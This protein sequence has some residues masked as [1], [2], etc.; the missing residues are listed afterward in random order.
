MRA[1]MA[2]LTLAM[3][4]A[5]P[6]GAEAETPQ[7]PAALTSYLTKG[8]VAPGDYRWLRGRFPG[9]TADEVQVFIATLRFDEACATQSRTAIRTRLAAMGQAFDPGEGLYARP[10]ECRQFMQIWVAGDVSWE[11]FSAALERVRPYALGILRATELA[12][13]QVLDHGG[14]AEQ[15]RTRP[16]GEQTLRYAWI[17]SQRHEG[18]T[19]G[20]SP[21]ERVIYE[22]ILLRALEERDQTNTRWLAD[23]VAAHGWPSRLSVGDAASGSAWLLVQ[24]ADADPAFQLAALRLMTPLAAK[25]AV[26]PRNFAM[27]TDRIQLKLSGKQRYGTQWRCDKGKRVPLPLAN[28]EVATD[29]LR[30]GVKLGTLKANELRIDAMYGPCPPAA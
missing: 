2:A 27:L 8:V 6:F 25:G 30:A 19:G 10:A 4:G 22:G 14:F 3:V 20:Y 7:I 15:L 9:A 18:A 11:A 17:E 12:E 28:S 16:L 23:K 5:A 26:D 21:L 13:Q 24:H 29:Q 1:I